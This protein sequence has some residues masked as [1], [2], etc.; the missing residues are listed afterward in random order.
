MTGGATGGL[1]GSAGSCAF[2]EGEGE[3][4]LLPLVERFS[5]LAVAGA[6]FGGRSLPS[7][8]G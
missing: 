6:V 8:D 1:G 5:E 4:E 7:P 2:V 3:F